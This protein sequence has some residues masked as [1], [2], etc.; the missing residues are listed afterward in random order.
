MRKRGREKTRKR[1]REEA[2]RETR[3]EGEF[4]LL[5]LLYHTGSWIPDG[6]S[7]A[8]SHPLT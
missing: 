1:V 2:V 5:M 8:P 7:H 3:D 6:L 4:M